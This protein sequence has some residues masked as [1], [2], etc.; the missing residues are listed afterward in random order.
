MF[1]ALVRI[2]LTWTCAWWELYTEQYQ[3]ICSSKSEQFPHSLTEFSLF[4]CCVWWMEG[5]AVGSGQCS[6]W[7]IHK[8]IMPAL[9]GRG[10]ISKH[11]QA[12][13]LHFWE[14]H[15][16]FLNTSTTIWSS[17]FRPPVQL[18]HIWRTLLRSVT[19]SVS[20]VCILGARGGG[21]QSGYPG[22]GLISRSQ[23]RVSVDQTFFLMQP[24]CTLKRGNSCTGSI[25]M[26]GERAENKR[27][28]LL[29]VTAECVYE[30]LRSACNQRVPCLTGRIASCMLR[31]RQQAGQNVTTGPE[32][33]ERNEGTVRALTRE[34]GMCE[35]ERK[36][37]S[38]ERVRGKEKLNFSMSTSSK[39]S[40]P[41][42]INGASTLLPHQLWMRRHSLWK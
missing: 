26:H 21:G 8:E 40:L 11:T 33:S 2:A 7:S 42:Q 12:P 41:R 39:R 27:Q 37:R 16:L 17:Q 29:P 20:E 34:M 18:R 25:Y 15:T 19:V 38:N 1:I 10:L 14:K 5:F 4:V 32:V 3:W 31:T 22:I 23:R 36:K 13:T 35:S 9:M 24:L 28:R 6:N 30:P